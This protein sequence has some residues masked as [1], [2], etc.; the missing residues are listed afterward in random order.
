MSPAPEGPVVIAGAGQA[1]AQAVQSLR[2]EGF[3][4]DILVYGDEPYLPYQRPPLSKAFLAG[5]MTED[6]LELKP[7]AFYTEAKAILHLGVRV[8]KILPAERLVVLSDGRRQAYGA[9]LVATG[10]RARTLPLPGADLPGIHSIR[11]IDDVKSFR[12]QA[13]PGSRIVIIGGGYIGLE[14]AAKSRKLGLEVTVVE[15]QPRI[16]ARVACETISSYLHSLHESHGVAIWTGM[17]VSGIAGEDRATGVILASG[18]ILPANLVLVAAGAVPSQELAEEAG[19]AVGNG[20]LVDAATR[21]SDP[22]IFAAG[23][24]AFLP[25]GLYGRR[26]RLE[27][28]QNAIDQAKAAGRAIAGGT[29]AYDPVPWFWSDQYDAKLQIAGLLDGFTRSRTEGDVAAGRFHVRYFSGD[30]LIAVASVNDARSHMLARRELAE[31]LAPQ[32]AG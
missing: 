2:A 17:G 8:T 23:D 24:V 1:A 26:V 10:S 32:P 31:G 9:L 13:A 19:L 20:I 14:V 4:G 15:T 12:A 11:S 7:P 22:F 3:S 16:L 27:S 25:S 5:E 21:T 28:V 6:R 30:R 18:E 29:V